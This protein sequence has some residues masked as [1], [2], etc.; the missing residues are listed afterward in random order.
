MIHFLSGFGVVSATDYGLIEIGFGGASYR[1]SSRNPRHSLGFHGKAIEGGFQFDAPQKES[2]ATS[3]SYPGVPTAC[4]LHRR[5]HQC[6]DERSG[7]GVDHQRIRDGPPHDHHESS[8][9]TTTYSWLPKTPACRCPC[10]RQCASSLQSMLPQ[11]IP[12]CSD[13]PSSSPILERTAGQRPDNLA[14]F[15]RSVTKNKTTFPN[16]KQLT[17]SN[18]LMFRS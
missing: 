8:L 9:T 5:S 13:W 16:S 12:V 18:K 14:L 11:R 3:R 6:E 1:P 17:H 10:H 15:S 2:P 4:H 7:T